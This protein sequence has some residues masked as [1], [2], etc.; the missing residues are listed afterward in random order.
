MWK[1]WGIV[2][3]IAAM[4]WGLGC[5][6]DA[7]D[8][9][10]STQPV[11]QTGV[12]LIVDIQG[13][14]DVRG[15]EFS[16]ARCGAEEVMVREQLDLEDLMLPGMIPEFEE[17]PFD[18]DS[19][20]LFADYFKVVD[21]GCYDI[22]IRP[23]RDGGEPSEDCLANWAT[24][25][26]VVESQTT[27]ILLVSQ[28]GV[29]E[30]G[31][32]DVVA[33][34]NHPPLIQSTDYSPSKF[35][36]ECEEVEVCV[37]VSD[38]NNDPLEFVFEQTNG[39]KLWSGPELMSVQNDGDHITACMEAV[40]VYPNNYEFRVRVYDKIHQEG[41]E[42]RIE[43]YLGQKSRAELTFPMYTNWDIEVHCY[44]PE[45][46]TYHRFEGVREIQRAPG[47]IPIWPF[48]FYC[49]DMWSGDTDE[50]CPGGEFA[51]ETVY[52]SCDGFDVGPAVDEPW[53]SSEGDSWIDVE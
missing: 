19:D 17:G 15:F 37:T 43:D 48:Q 38:P 28:C 20:H 26:Q 46:E 34:M 30:S 7:P 49:S 35:S 40:G 23:L 24:D 36:F 42:V 25:V 2:G 33:A 1:T 9:D 47:C 31:A 12:K 29:L 32:V 21:P 16:V 39:A 13:G 45:T 44:E 18:S 22:Q 52:P 4:S 5:G 8:D 14:S 11:E 50:T 51:P 3:S 6:M 10:D 27:E 53:K 41:E